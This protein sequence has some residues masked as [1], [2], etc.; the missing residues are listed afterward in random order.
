MRLFSYNCCS[1]VITIRYKLTYFPIPI[2]KA[3]LHLPFFRSSLPPF[4]W[5]IHYSDLIYPLHYVPPP[6]LTPSLLQGY[7][8]KHS[9]PLT[10]EGQ[11]SDIHSRTATSSDLV[12]DR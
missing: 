4:H 8:I 9:H 6:S 2:L 12:N 3:F 5:T 1:H 11:P 10:P 7:I